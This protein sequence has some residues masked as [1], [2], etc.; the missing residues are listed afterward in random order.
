MTKESNDLRRLS[1][2]EQNI[3]LFRL[4]FNDLPNLEKGKNPQDLTIPD[5]SVFRSLDLLPFNKSHFHH[6]AQL[7]HSVELVMPTVE[8][9][10]SRGQRR[11][12]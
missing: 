10:S 2:R 3:Y 12:G 4:C 11:E 5:P 9:G 1:P 6:L 7:T 8:D